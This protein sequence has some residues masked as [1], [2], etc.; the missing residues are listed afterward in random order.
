ML[1]RI[2]F[3][4]AQLGRR[5][6][7]ARRGIRRILQPFVRAEHADQHLHL[8]IVRR[9]IVIADRPVKA[10]AKSRARLEVVGPIAQRDAAPVIGAPA[11]HALPPPLELIRRFRVRIGVRLAR[12]FPAAVDRAI[13]EAVLLVRRGHA[14]QRSLARQLKHGHLGGRIKRTARFEHE[15]LHAFH[16]Q[17]VGRLAAARAGAD[18]DDVVRI[19]KCVWRDDWHGIESGKSGAACAMRCRLRHAKPQDDDAPAMTINPLS[20]QKPFTTKDGSTIRSILDRTNAPVEKQSLAEATLPR[21]L[22]HAAALPQDQRGILFH[23][24]RPRRDGN[25]RRITRSHRRR[26]DPHPSPR[27][28]PDHGA[29][30]LRFLCCCAPPYAHEDTYFS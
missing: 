2:Q 18:D 15:H 5:Q 1:L 3:A 21:R 26:R 14:P 16:G 17:R 23:S 20:S 12:D 6:Q 24:R 22:R 9:D 7:D 10:G 19:L 13:V 30:P 11:H 4:D 8:V 28:A 27:V 29:E 25:R